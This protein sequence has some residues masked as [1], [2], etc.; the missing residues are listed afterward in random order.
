PGIYRLGTGARIFDAVATA[1]GG[2][3]DADLDAIN[4]AAPIADGERVYVPRKGET[5]PPLAGGNPAANAI[6]NLN[7]AS[8]D[9][10]DALPGVGPSLAGAILEYR[11][12]HGR[13]RS[14]DD[15]LL[16]PGIGPAKV[17][18]LRARVQV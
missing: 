3:P 2:G 14:V 12:E 16:V 7:S 17:A 1:G 9:E 6:V 8:A 13:F 10:L 11:K 4:L 15:L 5:P 18:A